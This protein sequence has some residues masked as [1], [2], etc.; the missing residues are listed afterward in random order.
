MTAGARG[1]PRPPPRGPACP[2]A[3]LA[4][5]ACPRALPAAPVHP[6]HPSAPRCASGT[7]SGAP[8]AARAASGRTGIPHDPA[9]RDLL[10]A[11]LVAALLANLVIRLSYGSL[12]GFPLLAGATFGVLGMAEALAGNALRARIRRRPGS[13]SGAAAGRRPRGAGGQGVVAGRSDHGR[14]LGRAAASTCCR[15]APRSPRPPRRRRV[16]RGRAWSARSGWWPAR[17]GW[18]GA[19][20]PPT[21]IPRSAHRVSD[22][23][24]VGAAP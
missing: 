11:G 18:S 6:A 5:I 24:A 20:A 14:G 21:T 23:R 8:T 2:V 12:P 22:R 7:R 15:A 19:A 1:P 17:C 16:R 9:G 10:A 3:H 4:D 13:P